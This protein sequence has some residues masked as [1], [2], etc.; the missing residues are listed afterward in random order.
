[1]RTSA[2][3]DHDLLR[4]LLCRRDASEFLLETED[5]GL[6]LPI[7]SIPKHTRVAEELTKAIKEE[8]GLDTYC[9]FPVFENRP[10]GESLP[11]HAV[12]LWS[13][14]VAPPARMRWVPYT[15]GLASAEFLDQ[16][17]FAAV[18]ALRAKFEQFRSG[19]PSGA[20]A[21]PGW[22]Q[23]VIE[24]V[25]AQADTVGL[26]LTGNFRQFNASQTFSLLRFE[27]DGP[28]LWFKAVG[29]P[30]V[31]EFSITLYL[32]RFLHSS[33]PRVIASNPAWNAWLSLEVE[34]EHLDDTT[35]L[36]AWRRAAAT[37]ARLQITSRGHG[38]HLFEA[39]CRDIRAS[40]LLL[41]V[42]PFFERMAQLMELQAKPEPPP[43]TRAEIDSL[44]A[45]I[46]S[47]LE[48]L[49]TCEIP[50]VIGHLD[51]NPGNILVSPEQCVFLD[52]AEGAVGNPFYTFQY[53]LEHWRRVHGMELDSEKTLVCEYALSWR[54]FASPDDIE[55][56][57]ALAPAL[58]AFAYAST[59]GWNNPDAY[60]RPVIAG[61]LRSLVRRIKREVDELRD[62]RVACLP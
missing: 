8:W 29:E 13:G 17:D 49:N 9:L 16:G 42:D 27:T 2:Q 10:T 41:L 58:A 46:H 40:S 45:E 22:L 33:V 18:Q 32:A 36:N 6:Q 59:L 34:G 48:E 60:H 24:W 31:R 19:F 23:T 1:M 15:A 57:L 28:A 37:L 12:E 53:L 43:L 25:A 21:K 14:D 62:R 50:N 38:L 55:K 26:T 56:S 39:G 61:Y 54:A 11:I 3:L 47:C 4:V 44:G 51:F 20:F 5:K 7:I 52:W 30:N 35:P